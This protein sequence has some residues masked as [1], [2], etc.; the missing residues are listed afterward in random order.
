MRVGI[1]TFHYAPNYGAVLQA[2][3]LQTALEELGHE[4]VFIDYVP[5]YMKERVSALRGWGFGSGLRFFE[6][7]RQRLR[8][9]RRRNGFTRFRKTRLVCS[10]PLSTK[11]DLAAYCA[12]LDAVIVGSDQVWNLRWQKEFDDTYFLGFLPD[13]ASKVRRVA[14]APCFG[15]PEQPQALMESARACISKFDAVAMRNQFGLKLLDDMGIQGAKRVVDPAFFLPARD[16]TA[17][18]SGVVVY[19][20]NA[21]TAESCA[22]IARSASEV[23]KQPIRQISSETPVSLPCV[24]I[25]LMRYVQPD[26]WM[27]IVTG[28]SFVCSESFHGVVFALANAVPFVAA[29]DGL[30][31]HRIRDLLMQYGLEERLVEKEGAQR[32]LEGFD[33]PALVVDRLASD[34]ASSKQ[35]LRGAL[36]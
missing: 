19:A 23:L 4:P 24:G 7:F 10:V 36:A 11:Q 28:A 8:E 30:R 25:E 13:S 12:G 6:K 16:V 27:E 20:V 32:L 15:Q 5:G 17:P 29:S 21:S 9:Q 35:F 26:E 18:R 33:S 31:A 3:G 22:A 34:I 14:Y 1:L 2:L